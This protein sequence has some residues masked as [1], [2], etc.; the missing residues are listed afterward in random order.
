MVKD[1]IVAYPNPILFKKSR[2]ITEIEIKKNDADGIPINGL[3]EQLLMICL[4]TKHAAGLSAPQVGV[5][6]RMIVVLDR[7]GIPT[8]A[9]NPTIVSQEG[10]EI[11]KEGCLSLPGIS[12]T[13]KRAK[14]VVV[15]YLDPTGAKHEVA[16]EGMVARE[17]LH[18][19]DHI[20][21]V[22]MTQRS[23]LIANKHATK[24]MRIMEDNYQRRIAS[25]KKLIP[26]TPE[27]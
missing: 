1:E 17:W 12:V 11:G 15:S 21:G 26:E 10:S 19:I 13:I 24:T 20:E 4:K 14:R 22:L 27:K 2:E 16:A 5:S 8:I 18:E 25:S 23:N 6:L 3:A 7:E 9:I